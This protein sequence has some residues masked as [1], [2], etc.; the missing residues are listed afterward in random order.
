VRGHLVQELVA[1]ADGVPELGFQPYEVVL[2]E[3]E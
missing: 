2:E 3:G 1:R